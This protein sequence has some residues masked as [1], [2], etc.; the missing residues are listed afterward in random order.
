MF[1]NLHRYFF[2]AGL[3]YNVILTYDAVHTLWAHHPVSWSGMLGCVR[4]VSS[5]LPPLLT[6]TQRRLVSQ[7]YIAEVR[8][9]GQQPETIFGH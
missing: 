1:Q 7:K 8:V 2:Y 3:V 6:L 5:K 9:R 4:L